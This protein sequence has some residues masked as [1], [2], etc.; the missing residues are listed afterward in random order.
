MLSIT[1]HIFSGLHSLH[2]DPGYMKCS[3]CKAVWCLPAAELHIYTS[4]QAVTVFQPESVRLVFEAE[5]VGVRV[6][7]SDLM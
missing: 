4:K 2:S 7:E 6:G 3:A 5:G 1:S